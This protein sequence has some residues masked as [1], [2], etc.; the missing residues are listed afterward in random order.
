MKVDMKIQ[1]RLWIALIVCGMLALVFCRWV[2]TQSTS[3]ESLDFDDTARLETIWDSEGEVR[4]ENA[5]LPEEFRGKCSLLFKTT[6]IG[7]EILL[8]GKEIYQYGKEEKTFDFM[9]SPGSCWHIVDVPENSAGKKLEVRSLPAYSGYYG[10]D[11]VIF[12]GTRGECVLRIL[13]DSFGILLI[14]CGILFAGTVSLLLFL[15]SM[16]KKS[17]IKA[18]NKN[19]ILLNLGIFSLLIAVW[20]LDQCGFM[21][22]LIPNGRTLYYVDFFS[23]FLFPVPFLFLVHDICKSKYRKGAIYLSVL[24]LVNIV[25]EVILQCAGIIDIFKMLPVTHILMMV[26]LVY[27]YVVIH[28]EA[29]KLKNE[30]ACEFKYPLYIIMAFGAMELIMYYLRELKKTSVFIPLGTMVFIGMLIWIQVSRYYEQYVRKQKLVYLQKIA[31]MDMLTEA[32]NRN[33]YENMIRYLDEQE[34]ELRT[35]GVVLIDVDDLKMINDTYGHEKGDEALKLCYQCILQAFKNEK[36]CF[37]IGGDEFAYV[38]HREEKNQIPSCISVLNRILKEKA[39]DLSYPLSVSAGYAYYTPDTDIDFKDIVRRS[40][41]MLYRQKRRKKIGKTTNPENVLSYVE[42]IPDDVDEVILHEKKYQDITLDELC[43]II[44][45]ISPTSDNYPYII[46]FRTDFYYIAPQAMDRFCIPKNAFHKVI[47]YHRTFVYGPDYEKLKA[48]IDDLLNTERCSHCMEYRWLDLKKRPVWIKCKGYLVRDDNMNPIYMIGCVNELGGKQKADNVSGLLS[49]AGFREFLNESVS[50]WKKGFI[51][52]VG[53]DYFKEINENFGLEYGDFILRET[54]ACISACISEKQKVYKLLGDEFLI[55]DVS[56]DDE[57]DAEKLFFR[58]REAIDQFIEDNE[59]EVMYTIS[60][61]SMVLHTSENI[62]YSKVM[63][64]TDFALNEAKKRGRNRCY[65]FDEND[66]NLFIRKREVTQELRESVR[67]GCQDFITYYQ[68]VV[69]AG[70]GKLSGAEVLLRFSS[71]RFGMVSPAEFIP[72]LE[73]TGLIIPVGR[74]IMKEAMEKCSQVRRKMPDFKVNINISQVQVSKSDVIADIAAEME[75]AGLSSDAL[76]IE[77]T[78]SVL[79]EGNINTRHFLTEL[80]RMKIKLALDD[81]GTG[82]SNFHYLSELNPEIIKIDRSFTASAVKDEKEYYLLKQFCEMIH[83][84]GLKLCIEGVENED[85]WSKIRKL[86]PDFGQG[87][88]WGRP[89][90]FDNFIRQFVDKPQE[91]SL[92]C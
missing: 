25:A 65:A 58:I 27:I 29:V 11:L 23:F 66:Y 73:E 60:G 87:F 35:T 88:F 38:Y 40:D 61:G 81:F 37:R 67:N 3:R 48:D 47:E 63:K 84:L 77:L 12:F 33:A 62:D 91:V 42:K 16:R 31:N 32:M 78:E 74:W 18:D 26:T 86:R 53:I 20:S 41:T 80:K 22:F 2:Y 52:R 71:K 56:S 43:R 4:I 6:H 85:E 72:I 90:E 13:K 50:T 89:C 15:S 44:D 45:I 14:S 46:D 75:K 34:L 57:K 9:K 24:F 51:L 19:A 83:N 54:A 70:S 59:F 39:C 69:E 64:L 28:Y 36:N 82:Y 68:P 10:N 79:L 1:K 55:L 8:D 76:N 5:V 7:I 17:K 30:A 92:S 49:A 21:Q